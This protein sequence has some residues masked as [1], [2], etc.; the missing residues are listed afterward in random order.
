MYGAYVMFFLGR[1]SP[2]HPETGYKKSK[3]QSNDGNCER[4]QEKIVDLWFSY[5]GEI[6]RMNADKHV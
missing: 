5:G 4:K 2:N 6:K 1:F 3:K